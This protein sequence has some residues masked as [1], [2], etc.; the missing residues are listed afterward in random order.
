[1]NPTEQFILR[2]EALQEGERSRLRRLTGKEL[3]ETIAGFDLFTGIW[4][5]LREHSDAAPRRDAAWLVAKL[6]SAFPVRTSSGGDCG[7]SLPEALGR[8]E[9]YGEFAGRYHRQ[10]FDMLLQSPLSRLEQ[11][12]RWALSVVADAVEH[13]RCPGLD[14]VQLLSDISI[15]DRGKEHARRVDIRE[16]WADTY[17][18]AAR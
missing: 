9:P 14:W 16:Q 6:H 12:L 17:L 5:P 1:M 8:H 11:P 10:R 13:N 18:K 2:L 15:W 3:D 7:T 4:W